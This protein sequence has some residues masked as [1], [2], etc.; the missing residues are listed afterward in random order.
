MNPMEECPPD[1]ITRKLTIKCELAFRHRGGKRTKGWM[2]HVRIPEI[3]Y[4]TWTRNL[5]KTL[6]KEL[7]II[8][9][10]N[11]ELILEEY[12]RKLPTHAPPPPDT[13]TPGR[14]TSSNGFDCSSP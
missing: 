9:D 5:T 14:N 1:D 2:W 3:K 10:L 12:K 7:A 8:E 11:D 13:M 4:E 6:A